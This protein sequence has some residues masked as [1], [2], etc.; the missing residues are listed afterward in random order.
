MLLLVNFTNYLRETTPICHYVFKKTKTKRR[1]SNSFCES[2]MAPVTKQD[3]D[4]I[5][6]KNYKP[7]YIINI[8]AKIPNKY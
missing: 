2:K 7:I 1:F 4:I 5:R 8:A 3:K 6:Q